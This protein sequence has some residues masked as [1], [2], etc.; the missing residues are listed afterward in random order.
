MGK[1]PGISVQMFDS[2]ADRCSLQKVL[3]FDHSRTKMP[4]YWPHVSS[5][6]DN[7]GWFVVRFSPDIRTILSPGG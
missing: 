1:A 5:D 2:N 7:N 6:M 4:K 3:M